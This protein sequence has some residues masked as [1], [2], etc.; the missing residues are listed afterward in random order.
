MIGHICPSSSPFFDVV[1]PS[2]LRTAACVRCAARA[3]HHRVRRPRAGTAGDVMKVKLCFNKR[4]S[5]LLEFRNPS[6]ARCALDHLQHCPLYDQALDVVISQKKYISLPRPGADDAGLAREYHDNTL[7]RFKQQGSRQFSYVRA[8][9]EA[10]HISNVPPQVGEQGLRDMLAPYG[11]RL[12]GGVL[13]RR[14]R[15]GHLFVTIPHPILCLP[16]PHQTIWSTFSPCLR[17]WPILCAQFMTM[18][19]VVVGSDGSDILCC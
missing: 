8:P 1:V 9:C 19:R 11:M 18:A 2:A 13:A 5:A 4:D 15:A 16:P 14:A 10:L 12:C 17:F 7:H 3:A 6:Q